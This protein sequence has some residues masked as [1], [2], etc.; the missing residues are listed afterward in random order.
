MKWAVF[1]VED[2]VHI[3]QVLSLERDRGWSVYGPSASTFHK[4][5]KIILTLYEEDPDFRPVVYFDADEFPA[6]HLF[7]T[8]EQAERASIL[9]VLGNELLEGWI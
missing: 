2:V 3:G 1:K 6:A 8:E 5:G 4:R 7:D 9:L